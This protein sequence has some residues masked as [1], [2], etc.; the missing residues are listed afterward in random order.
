M[1]MDV[2]LIGGQCLLVRPSAY[3]RKYGIPEKNQTRGQG[4]GW[5]YGISRNIEEIASEIS[6]HEIFRGDQEKTMWNFQES[7]F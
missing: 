5:G 3:Y 2:V 7:W 1:L 6:K 4:G